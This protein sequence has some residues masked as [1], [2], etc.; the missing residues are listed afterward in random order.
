[1]SQCLKVTEIVA[2]NIASEA[3]KVYIENGQKFIKNTKNRWKMPKLKCDILADF[4]PLCLSKEMRKSTT[5]A[6]IVQLSPLFSFMI[7]VQG[8][9]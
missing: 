6:F 4:Q 2:F 9:T 3:S 7:M 5:T 1:M 8:K